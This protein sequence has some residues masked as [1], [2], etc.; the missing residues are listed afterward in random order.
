MSTVTTETEPLGAVIAPRDPLVVVGS[1]ARSLGQGVWQPC[2][3]TLTIVA[4]IAATGI[5]GADYP[6]HHFRAALWREVGPTLWN[7]QWYGGHPTPT[8]GVLSPPI[9]ALFGAF[10][11]VATAAIVSTFSFSLLTTELVPGRATVLANHVFAVLVTTNV[12]VGRVAFGIGLACALLAIVAWRYRLGIMAIGA[13]GLAGLASPVAGAFVALAATAALLDLVRRRAPDR[14][15]PATGIGVMLAATSPMLVTGAL[16]DALGTFPFRGG[17]LVMSIV[18]LLIT[19]RWGGPSVVR[20]GAVLVTGASLAVFIVPN[21]LGGNIVRLTQ[22]VG[23][24]L[25][26]IA[27]GSRHRRGRFVLGVLA[28]SAIGWSISPG[29]VAAGD[30]VGDPSTGL[31]FHLPLI[32]E[33]T[34][35]NADGGPV[36]RLEIPFTLNHWES[37][38]VAAA[39]PYARGWERQADIDRNPELYDPRLDET[40]YRRWVSDHAVR[41]I[42]VP[43]VD[44]DDDGG[45]VWEVDFL[46]STNASWIR[47]VWSDAH[48]QLYEVVDY[49]PI[50]EPPGRLVGQAGDHVRIRVDRA[51]TVT[52][53]FSHDPRMSISSGA[54]MRARPDGWIE[55]VLPRAGEY[56]LRVALV[57]AAASSSCV[58]TAASGRAS[59][60]G[61]VGSA[62]AVLEEAADADLAVV[63]AE[64]LDE[65]VALDQEAVGQARRQP[66]VD[67]LL[68]ERL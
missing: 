59:G 44:I 27:A 51:A 7:F 23:V 42:A 13:A 43:D 5:R 10:V 67:R 36:G 20:V 2:A 31:A 65:Q 68:G 28:I 21:P 56:E 3:T 18:V 60:T 34:R 47:R 50:V 15:G 58:D 19:A 46:R 32:Q 29:F 8:Y 25:L 22:I 40:V 12:V 6:A 37:Y 35:R 64:R 33:V 66:T 30:A 48:W 41:W 63:R 54:C 24:P 52:I 38:Y 16:F 17:H 1:H 39:V 61:E 62:G 9:V 11:S 53:R 55:A 4:L 57:H 26:V 45:G 49:V 14:L